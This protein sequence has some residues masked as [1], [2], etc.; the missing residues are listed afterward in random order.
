MLVLTRKVHERI[1]IADTI[2]VEVLEVRNGKV[3]LG[4]VA[5]WDV[6]IH[7]EE[8]FRRIEDACQDAVL[9]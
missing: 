1:R 3:K 8:L 6:P 7:R 4:F 5:P 9:V 2:E